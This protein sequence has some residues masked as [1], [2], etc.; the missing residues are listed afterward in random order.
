MINKVRLRLIEYLQPLFLEKGYKYKKKNSE[1]YLSDKSKNILAIIVDLIS[2]SDPQRYM[3]TMRLCIRISELEEVY[4]KYNPY[5]AAPKQKQHY[6]LNINQSG[7]LPESFSEGEIQ[8][9][10]QKT[11]D[12]VNSEIFPILEKFSIK[13]N[14]IENLK[15][16]DYNAWITSD[17]LARYPILLSNAALESD[18]D[19]FDKYAKE[20]LDFCQQSFAKVHLPMA[21]SI[22]DGINQEFFN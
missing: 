1:F 12:I 22:I 13:T 4:V 21:N 14:L 8:R 10:G 5:I 17:R 7:L 16:E 9:I 20:F 11:W 15:S 3:V 19:S 2:T 18:R 6:T